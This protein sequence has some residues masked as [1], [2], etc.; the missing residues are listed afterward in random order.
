MRTFNYPASRPNMTR[1]ETWTIGHRTPYG[2]AF[3]PN[4]Q[5]WVPGTWPGWRRQAEPDRA[6]KNYGWPLAGT[7]P[8]TTRVPVPTFENQPN[9]TRAVIQWMPAIGPGMLTFYRGAM[10]P[11][12]NGS[13]LAGGMTTKSLTRIVFDGKGGAVAAERWDIG[14]GVRDGEVGT[15]RRAVD[16]RRRSQQ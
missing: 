6:G 15:R 10:F 14:F 8:T 16:F 12:W 3:A 5:L 11:Q 4:G 9:L 13:A 7:G 1:A 2:M